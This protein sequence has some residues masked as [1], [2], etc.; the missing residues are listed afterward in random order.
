MKQRDPMSA[1]ITHAAAAAPTPTPT[2]SIIPAH[3]PAHLVRDVDL[4]EEIS[5][6][7]IDAHARAAALHDET[8]PIFYVPRLGYIGGAWVPRRAE[9]LRRILQDT[10]TFSNSG[11]TPFPQMLGEAWRLIPLDIDPPDHAKYRALLNP[12]FSPKRVDALEADIRAQ[13][14]SLL[15][16][17]AANGRC[18]F[19]A[20]FAEQFPT[21]IFLRVMGWD[22]GEV[23]RF[24]EWTQTIVKGMDIQAV[25]GAVKQVRDYLRA[26][27]AERRAA[28]GD[29]FTS[30]LL[31]A[32]VDAQ[33]LTDDEVFGI[34][35]LLFLAGLDT[36]TSS[37]G[38]QFMHLARNP[39]H[40][41][42]LRAH[43][44]R[45][46]QAVDE[47][48]RAY[49][50]VN[51]RLTVT[52]DVTIGEA[53]MKA[54][55]FVL[56]STELGNLDPEQFAS[57]ATV[58]FNRADAHVPHMAFAYGVHRCLG[59][60]L[61]RRELRIA[62]E[63]WLKLPPFQLDADRTVRMRASGVFGLDNLHLVWA[64]SG[65]AAPVACA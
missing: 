64:A 33:L 19:N 21:L 17:F 46:P 45:I 38:F 42:E 23:T 13:A 56:I 62:L 26:R 20:E 9:D 18:D 51:M 52:R 48:L 55:D 61:A 30:S 34:C 4:W 1:D 54:G 59:S 10:E 27:I 53:T 25:I 3:I 14:T 57:P 41:E 47:M 24:V 43:P 7:G 50:I 31:R 40:Q 60:H 44:E 12:L 22:T 63:L 32:E 11:G 58:D 39:A 28:P 29:D 15:N 16:G 65:V 2:P 8:P 49:S 36:V 37:L 5:A 6:A 35:F